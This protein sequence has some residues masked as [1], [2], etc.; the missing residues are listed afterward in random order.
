MAR[1]INNPLVNSLQGNIGSQLVMKQYAYGTVVSKFP[2]M[3]HIKP[4]KKQKAER[5]KFKEAVAYA[6]S[7][8]HNPEKKTAYQQKV[9]P[10]QTV[11]HFALKEY[12]NS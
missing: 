6:Q 11:Y 2:D 4:S 12:L 9:K 3:D 7:I 10:G 8:V 1:V 5:N